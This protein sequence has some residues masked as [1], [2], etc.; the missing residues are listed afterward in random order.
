MDYNGYLLFERVWGDL[1]D[2]YRPFSFRSDSLFVFSV[3]PN[4]SLIDIEAG[5]RLCD[6]YILGDLDIDVGFNVYYQSFYSFDFSDSILRNRK[7]G[8]ILGGYPFNNYF[9]IVRVKG[10]GFFI[11]KKTFFESIRIRDFLSFQFL[12]SNSLL[13]KNI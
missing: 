12:E 5:I 11:V 13:I 10:K 2:S 8:I 7:T 3:F 9:R 6:A 1:F 4:C